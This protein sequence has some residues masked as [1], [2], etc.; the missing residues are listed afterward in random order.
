MT[1]ALVA[2]LVAV[3]LASLVI[4]VF[5]VRS[6]RHW[7]VESRRLIALAERHAA[8]LHAEMARR[9]LSLEEGASDAPP[10]EPAGTAELGQPEERRPERPA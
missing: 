6:V 10:R 7:T 9:G 1:V 3:T 2:V 4:T 8:E 5:V